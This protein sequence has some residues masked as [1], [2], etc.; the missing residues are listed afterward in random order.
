MNIFIAD[1]LE[2]KGKIKSFASGNKN[3]IIF[4]CFL[5]IP[6]KASGIIYGLIYFS[7]FA[8]TPNTPMQSF[9]ISLILLLIYVIFHSL[10]RPLFPVKYSNSIISSLIDKKSFFLFR[11]IFLAYSAVPLSIFFFIGLLSNDK[12]S[13]DHITSVLF[14]VTSFSCIGFF[15]Y[16]LRL[17]SF[18]SLSVIFILFFIFKHGPLYNMAYTAIILLVAL[19]LFIRTNDNI[20]HRITEKSFLPSFLLS[21]YFINLLYFIKN[22]KIFTINLII[23]VILSYL[24]C[25]I[26]YQ[27]TPDR[28]I[29]ITI[30]YLSF[31]L[32][33]FTL[34]FYNI[35]H[36]ENKHLSYLVNF[37]SKRK[38]IFINYTLCLLLFIICGLYYIIMTKSIAILIFYY[39][40]IYSLTALINLSRS[41]YTKLITLCVIVL[42]SCLGGYIYA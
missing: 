35:I 32:Y 14:L 37:S 41:Q 22:K 10:Q 36:I 1:A 9:Y 5:F 11:I 25:Y 19:N 28:I 8:V 42:F 2:Y 40:G 17:F 27:Q 20:S 12:S 15:L 23:S 18:L 33:I 24:V 34:F 38:F 29:Y 39:S 3:L 30:I 16:E 7:Q 4:L 31:T 13:I 6:A 26:A 21:P